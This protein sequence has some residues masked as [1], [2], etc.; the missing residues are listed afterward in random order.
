L[1]VKYILVTQPK[2]EAPKSPYF[3]LAKKYSLKIDFCP[4]IKVEPIPASRFRKDKINVLDYP[5]VIFISRNAVDQFFRMCGELR[6]T[7]PESTKYFCLSDSVAYYL[8][9]YVQF[10]K[11]KILF[12]NQ[13]IEDL[14]KV[15]NKYPEEKYLVPC[16]DTPRQRV[17]E[18]LA[19]H[20]LNFK[21]AVMY[22]TECAELSEINIRLYDIIVLF[23]P[24]DVK[25]LFKNF[26][27]FRQQNVKIAAFGPAV[28]QAV[29]KAKLRLDIMAPIPG[30]PSMPV[31]LDQFIRKNNK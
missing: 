4:F 14:L 31:V 9:K 22:K 13:T 24:L 23:S 6:V 20:K 29:N 5:A 12:G 15:I 16:A 19:E 26:P 27:K 1:K 18:V 8:Q 7:P 21:K 25:S 17:L 28:V 2:P 3:D 30:A 11:R 10:R